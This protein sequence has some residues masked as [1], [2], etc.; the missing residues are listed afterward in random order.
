VKIWNRLKWAAGC[1]L[2]ALLILSEAV[3]D[4]IGFG[5]VNNTDVALRRGM[6][7]KVLVR[8]PE[9]TCVWVKESATDQQ[10]I[11]WYHVNAGLNKDYTNLDY[12]GWMKA[13]FI[14]AGDALWHDIT[15]ISASRTGLIALRK[16]GATI[17]T[18]RPIVSRDGQRWES[19]LGRFDQTRAVQVLADESNGYSVLTESGKTE[20]SIGTSNT[21]ENFRLLGCA[22]TLFGIT[23][24]GQVRSPLQRFAIQW[25]YPEAGL[26]AEAL[27]HIVKLAGSYSRLL[28]LSGDGQVYSM[29]LQNDLDG[30]SEPEWE[31]WTNMKNIS[32]GWIRLHPGSH[33]S[34]ALIGIREDGTVLAAPKELQDRIGS[35]TGMKQIELNVY[36]ALGLKED[37]TAISLPMVSQ[38]P[39]V[40]GW[41]DVTSIGIGSDYAVG[42]KK[43]GTLVFAGEHIFMGEGH[44]RK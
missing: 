19:P 3:A 42:L 35:W 39:D 8:L 41:R 11:L 15:A 25:I 21:G 12:D 22:D 13:E 24:D 5:Y 27:S 28:L 38:A 40:S 1:L 16:D 37:G 31:K 36:W 20:Y 32:G 17:L 9:N 26:D 29:F 44:H 33:D 7:G 43:D 23:F 4:P 6:G 14:A 30:A 2:L 34:A 10:G 18:G